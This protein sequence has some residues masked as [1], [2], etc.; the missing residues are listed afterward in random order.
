MCSSV[1]VGSVQFPFG[2]LL[3][4]SHASRITFHLPEQTRQRRCVFWHFTRRLSQSLCVHLEL[5]GAN[6]SG[7]MSLFVLTHILKNK[8]AEGEEEGG[9]RG[10]CRREEREA[11]NEEGARGDKYPCWVVNNFFVGSGGGGRSII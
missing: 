9:S 6:G 7:A 2:N 11:S 3:H 10:M 5:A 4:L 8:R 1:H